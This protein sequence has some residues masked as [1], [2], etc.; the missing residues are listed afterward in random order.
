[1]LRRSW[2]I[3]RGIFIGAGCMLKIGD[4][5]QGGFWAGGWSGLSEVALSGEEV[6]DW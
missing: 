6:Q 3:T 2:D 5:W 4:N 1:M